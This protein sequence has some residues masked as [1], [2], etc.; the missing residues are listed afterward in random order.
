MFQE[1]LSIQRQLQTEA[2]FV[3]PFCAN[4]SCRAHRGLGGRFYAHGS[5]RIKRFPYQSRRFRCSECDKTFSHSYFKLHYRQKIWGKNEVIFYEQRTGSSNCEIAR[6]IGHSEHL[7]RKRIVKM[8]RWGLIK[9][10]ALSMQ[11][12]ISEPIAYDGLENFS[13]SQYEPNNLNH[14]VGKESLFIYDFNLCPINRKG[15]MSERQKTRARQLENKH[16]KFPKNSIRT[17]TTD[18]LRRLVKRS[19]TPLVLFTDRHYQYRR[20]IDLDI[21]A[22]KFQH[23]TVSSKI[24][25]NFKNKLFA[26]N[27]IDMQARH[28]MCAYKRETIAF[29]KHSVAMLEKFTLNMIFRNYMRPKFWNKHKRDPLAHTHSPAMLLG[30]SDR[31]M[32]FKEFFDL[33]IAPTQVKLSKDWQNLYDRVDPLS[34]RKIALSP[35][36]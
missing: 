9:H 18:I 13:A 4:P 34:R 19:A 2:N 11:L 5:V 21:G 28:N 25:R 31:I 23:I 33:R 1:Y 26:V 30:I 29:S 12:P 16:G 6:L 15:R 24:A 35:A 3:P 36:L 32:T 8:S 27:N 17:S 14:A 7:V 10:A 20:S 22:Q